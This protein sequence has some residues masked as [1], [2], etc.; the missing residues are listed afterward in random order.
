EALSSVTVDVRMHGREPR[1]V[2]TAH[3]PEPAESEAQAPPTG[4]DAGTSRLTLRLP[5]AVKTRLEEAGGGGG[6]A[7][8]SGCGGGGVRELGVGAGGARGV[9]RSAAGGVVAVGA[10]VDRIRPRL[11]RGSGR[12]R[13]V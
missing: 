9:G 13:F 11:I 6:G 8:N 5:G 1:I 2:V 12:G 10:A 7:G 4:D 3:E